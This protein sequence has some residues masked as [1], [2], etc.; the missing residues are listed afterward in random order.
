MRRGLTLLL[1]LGALLATAPSAY[2]AI[3]VVDDDG[4][5]TDLN[6][7][8]ATATH[9]TIQD[10]VN[11]ATTGADFVFVCPGTYAEM[12]TV[13]KV[14]TL[15]GARFAT[16]ARHVSRTGLPDTEAVVTGSSGSTAFNV[17]EDDVTIDGFTV[18]GATNQNNLGAGIVIGAGTDGTTIEDT[19][20][21]NNL[22]G[23]LLANNVLSDPTVIQR[24]LFKENNQTGSTS[25]TAI[26]SDQFVAGGDLNGA[27]ITD[28]SFTGNDGSAI[29]LAST[30][31]ANPATD[32]AIT[33]NTFDG[34]GR[35]VEA[36][37][38]QNS[39]IS[40]NEVMNGAGSD[41]SLEDGAA[42]VTFTENRLSG[43]GG[44][45]IG[46]R[47]RK[48]NVG[49]APT[50]ITAKCNSFSGYATAGLDVAA[51]AH[52]GALVGEFN[53]WNSASGP[54][55][56]GNLGGTGEQLIDPQSRVDFHPF[57]ASDTD[58]DPGTPGFQC[59]NG[60]APT[61]SLNQAVDQPDPTATSPINFTATFSE[62]VTGFTESDVHLVGSAGATTT[63][64]TPLDHGATYRVAVS[65]MS[66]PGTVTAFTLTGAASDVSGAT[67]GNSSSIDNTVF[68][69][70]Q[71]TLT[72][73]ASGTVLIGG[74]ISDTATL[75]GGSNPTGTISFKVYGPD[76][77]NCTGPSTL[78][79]DV[80]VTGNGSYS[81]GPY[82][83]TATGT[84]RWVATYSGDADNAQA[85]GACNDPN[86]SVAVVPPA[87]PDTDGDG[88]PDGADNCPVDANT[89]QADSDS[90]G[91]GDACERPADAACL[92]LNARNGTAA[93]DRLTGTA[94]GDLLRGLAGNDRIKGGR[95]ADCL[96]GGLGR[97]TISG[98][99]GGDV[100]LGEAGDDRLM[101]RGGKD[102][103]VA[104][105]GRN[106]LFG[107]AGRDDLDAVNGKRDR[108]NC[109]RGR[110]SARTDKRDRVRRCERVQ[111]V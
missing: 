40:R 36:F 99:K 70:V 77:A 100:I 92:N 41:V 4:M 98:G 95:G 62:P 53:W 107:A 63:V 38:L 106:R 39:S 42:N 59:D 57:L 50:N 82:T 11:A 94:A 65:G 73:A 58:T 44:A 103:I 2:G 34:N 33:S 102:R 55:N 12:V 17:T 6:C 29:L 47:L 71:P 88:T 3:R 80:P 27:T 74:S 45:E 105:P 111:R 21:Q 64:V 61:M 46:L 75:S 16:D 19:I 5:A 85:M 60:M 84:Y 25:G 52:L 90:N 35:A 93:A 68:Y 28:N 109:G 48:S 30:Q 72:T 54:T 51:G 69:K 78:V 66:G 31:P 26:Y 9:M 23:L 104:G 108:V 96:L 8:A 32:V 91:T 22:T 24:N 20:V 87:P 14:L 15:Q 79:A 76:D 10:A 101:G 13:N 49:L 37:H 56:P 97:D 81:S 67:T 86:E 43:T 110:D 18:Q 89:D 83:P 1:C 7:D